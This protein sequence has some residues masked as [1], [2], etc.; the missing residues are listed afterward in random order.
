MFS[1][2]GF[3]RIP[4][5]MALMAVVVPLVFSVGTLQIALHS[6]RQAVAAEARSRRQSELALCQIVSVLDTAYKTTPPQ[7]A[8]GREVAKAVANLIVVNHCP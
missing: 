4:W 6:Q 1:E 2:R 5:Y 3:V 7:T 8:A